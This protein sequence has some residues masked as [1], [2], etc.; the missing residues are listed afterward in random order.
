MWAGIINNPC[1]VFRMAQ[2]QTSAVVLDLRDHGESDKIVTFFSD[3]IGKFTGIAKGAKRSKKRFVNKL[4]LFTLLFVDFTENIRSTLV[5]IDAAE[6]LDPHVRLRENY[7]AY[8]AAALVSEMY[9]HGT[10]ELDADPDLFRLLYWDLDQL[11]RGMDPARSILVF[12]IKFYTLLGYQPHLSGCIKCAT[13]SA[14]KVPYRFHINRNA[15][16][17]ASCAGTSGP[18]DIILSLNTIMMLAKAMEMGLDKVGRLQFS[19]TSII[20][21]TKFLKRY[22]TSLLHRDIHSWQHYEKS[23]FK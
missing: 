18:E 22:G 7:T 17:C 4:E 23:V 11:T 12:L 5:R 15:I 19:D 21:A 8:T 6:L 9:I 10:R 14:K 3:T 16:V 13:L 20:E 2:H 1:L